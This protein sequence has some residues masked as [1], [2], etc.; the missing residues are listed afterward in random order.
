MIRLHHLATTN[1]QTAASI[2]WCP[3]VGKFVQKTSKNHVPLKL[4]VATLPDVVVE[5]VGTLMR[6]PREPVTKANMRK[7]VDNTSCPDQAF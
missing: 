2:V 4:E 1:L 6:A 7:A 5:H 3:K